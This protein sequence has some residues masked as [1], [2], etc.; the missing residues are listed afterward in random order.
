M[1]NKI[2]KLCALLIIFAVAC[3]SLNG[4]AIAAN[5][6]LNPTG[7]TQNGMVN[8]NTPNFTISSSAVIYVPGNY[9]T[10]QAAIDNAS[11][12][13]TIIVRDGT[14][15]ENIDVNKRLTIQSE[16]GSDFTLV[17]AQSPYGHVFNVTADYVNISGFTVNGASYSSG[18]YLGSGNHCNITDNNASNS[19]NGIWLDSSSNNTISSNTVNS[20]DEY[21][22]YLT[23]SS[24]PSSYNIISNNNASNNGVGIYLH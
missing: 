14:Y 4:I 8:D 13:D 6:Q 12:G 9:S 22:I 7:D 24:T 16:N 21:G 23:Y 18:I 20:N 5:N 15:V 3:S 11:E 19:Y 1:K 10:I 17:Q 2:A